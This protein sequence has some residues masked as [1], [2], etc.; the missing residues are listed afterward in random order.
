MGFFN[1]LK[2]EVWKVVRAILILGV[3]ISAVI[4]IVTYGKR[5]KRPES[6]SMIID[7][8]AGTGIDDAFAI[9]LALV[10]PKID[11]IGLTS[12]QHNLHPL[13]G[14]DSTVFLNQRINELI[15]QLNDT[16]SIP[17][18]IGSSEPMNNLTNELNASPASDYII[19][20]VNNLEFEEKLNVITLGAV[21]NLA[22]AIRKDSTIASRIRWF[23]L[24]MIYNDSDRIWNKNER[25]TRNDLDAM[26]YLLN[27]E[28]LET[29]IMSISAC[30]DYKFYRKETFDMLRN[31]APKYDYLI[32]KWSDFYP[33]Q[34]EVNMCSLSLI[35]SIMNPDMA[36][37]KDVWTPPENTRRRITVYTWLNEE[38]MF[39]EYL[40][41]IKKDF[42]NI[43]SDV[44]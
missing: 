40:K 19:E 38:K 15:L 9:T 24:G 27:T 30:S 11:V 25:N 18:P 5:I 39:R 1:R 32:N 36:T 20:Q 21:T 8:D 43:Y 17:H 29:N 13:Q 16:L 7:A 2:K 10:D 37:S 42:E 34:R 33:E 22:E 4:T 3:I 26:D 6:V 28:E 41:I 35:Q 14:G 44:N 23:G 12:A 31:R